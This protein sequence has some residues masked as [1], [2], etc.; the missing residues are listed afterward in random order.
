MATGKNPAS[1]G[2]ASYDILLKGGRV[3]DPKNGRNAAFDVAINGGKIAQVQPEID[4]AQARQ[5]YDV[6][7]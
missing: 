2:A 5:V 7:G 1:N 6:A 4:S 3:I